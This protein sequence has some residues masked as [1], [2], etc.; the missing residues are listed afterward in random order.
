MNKIKSHQDLKKAVKSTRSVIMFS[1]PDCL[2]CSIVKTAIVSVEQQFPLI[3]FH[4]TEDLGFAKELN[5]DA[6]PVLVFYE[7]GNE[8]GRLI[9]SGKVHLLK[10]IFNLWFFKE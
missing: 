2:H 6:F 3:D 4:Y 9:G 5:I 1:K 7:K 10:H 8:Q